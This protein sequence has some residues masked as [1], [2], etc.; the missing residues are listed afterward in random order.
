MILIG[1]FGKV[2]VNLVD[3]FLDLVAR[4]MVSLVKIISE[5]PPG[6]GVY[7]VLIY[8]LDLLVDL[9]DLQI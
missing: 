6:H 4:W 2:T 9:L 8:L 3:V 1:K 5:S 7:G